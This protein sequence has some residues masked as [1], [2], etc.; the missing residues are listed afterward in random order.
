MKKILLIIIWL[1]VLF[2]S[3]LNADSEVWGVAKKWFTTFSKKISLKYSNE[4]QLVYF[5]WFSVKLNHLLATKDFSE[6][7][8]NLVND[9]IILS[10]EKVFII[11]KNNLEKPS[12]IILKTNK[13]LSDFKLFS[14]NK[15]NIFIENWIWYSY[16]FDSHLTF[17]KWT[18][19][20]KEDLSFNKID[21]NSSLVF[22]R[23]DNALWF[24]N[25]YTKIKLISDDI[26]Y[27]IPDKFNFLSEVR[28]DKRKLVNETNESFLSLKLKAR[29]LTKWKTEKEKIEILYKYVLE[30]IEYPASFSLK[31]YEIFSGINTYENKSW[32]CEWY[33]K[34]LMYML[35][36]AW[37]SDVEV[38]RWYV[39][40]AQDFPK[41]WHAWLKIW[42]IY[43]DPTFDDPIWQ[44][45]TRTY[46]KYRYFWLPYDLFYAN[47]YTFEKIP[48]YLK[49]ESLDYR[50]KYITKK[51]TPLIS[52]YRYSNYN[53][54]KPYTL[55]L[56]HWIDIEK[57][58][59]IEDL[60]KIMDSYKVENFVF[61]KNGVSKSIKTL[62]Y[63]KLTNLQVNSILDQLNYN[64]YWHYLFEWKLEN[65]TSEYRL[66]YNVKFN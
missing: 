54:L 43:Y 57:K 17:P 41:V 4:K 3:S 30:N 25:N 14:Y 58:L 59:D 13:L 52:K 26:I 62:Q 9:L 11:E 45:E 64:L 42:D 8:I 27:W 49:E 5:K 32:V 24:A 6:V 38:L 18:I 21:S 22:L 39:L 12:K 16:I 51:I 56:D 66:A 53:I 10:N 31:D 7:Q 46:S 33:T 23:E 35:N 50:K 48:N 29:E 44:K 63:Y 34:I 15:K 55:K 37:I 40:D 60:K 19:I 28:D 61:K 36:F 20:K 65:W 47:R 1:L 2:P